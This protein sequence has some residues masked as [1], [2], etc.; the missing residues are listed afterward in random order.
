MICSPAKNVLGA[1][2][3]SRNR[4]RSRASDSRSKGLKGG[5]LYYDGQFDDARF[6]ITLLRTLFDQGGTA[7]NYA[8]VVGLLKNNGT[9]SGVVAEDRET[10]ERFDCPAKTVINATG[11]S[12][13][14]CAR[15]T[16]PAPTRF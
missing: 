10:G 12:L 5:I 8:R 13:T 4:R 7:L 2:A 1:R 11:F 14:S 16:R 6:A 3:F 15:W 9:V